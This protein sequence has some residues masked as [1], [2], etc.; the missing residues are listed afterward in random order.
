MLISKYK[1]III[2]RIKYIFFVKYFN[3]NSY[4]FL[5]RKVSFNQPNIIYIKLKSVVY[6]QTDKLLFFYH[7]NFINKTEIGINLMF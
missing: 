2:N 7:N 3:R 1:I 4:N 5:T 6:K